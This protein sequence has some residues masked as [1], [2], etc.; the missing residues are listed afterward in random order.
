MSQSAA[1]GGSNVGLEREAVAWAHS[2]SDMIAALPGPEYEWRWADLPE[3]PDTPTPFP[4]HVLHQH[5]NFSNMAIIYE[6][7]V[8]RVEGN[9]HRVWTTDARY[10]EYAQSVEAERG[11]RLPCKPNPHRRGFKTIDPDRGIYLCGHPDCTETYG[12]Y[13]IEEVFG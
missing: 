3:H 12:R 13:V 10:Y 5:N 2:H 7:E 6:V 1:P 8:V 11:D 4:E 9:D